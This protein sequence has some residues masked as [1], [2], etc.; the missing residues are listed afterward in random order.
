MK[1]IEIKGWIFARPT[2]DAEGVNFEF[3]THD[4]TE[5]AKNRSIDT[6]G[7]YKSYRKVCDHVIRMDVPEFDPKTMMVEALE[8]EKIALRAEFTR[9]VTEI[10]G[11]ISKLLALPFVPTAEVEPAPTRVVGDVSDVVF[12]DSDL[13]L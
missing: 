5:W 10:E 3:S 12:D 4:Y 11:Q 2:W 6:D 8:A 1:T 7:A 9:R 13:P